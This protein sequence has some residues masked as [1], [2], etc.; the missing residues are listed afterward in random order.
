MRIPLKQENPEYI[1]PMKI[2]E[3]LYI[4]LEPRSSISGLGKTGILRSMAITACGKISLY[5]YAPLLPEPGKY[6]AEG[7][8][9][10]R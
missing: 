6:S 3:S 7:I 1:L 10:F 4:L 9:P 2:L 8:W 5:Q